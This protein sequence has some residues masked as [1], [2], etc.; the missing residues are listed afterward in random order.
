MVAA[1]RGVASLND[2]PLHGD[3]HGYIDTTGLML[4][5]LT[6]NPG[7]TIA[8]FNAAAMELTLSRLLLAAQIPSDQARRRRPRRLTGGV[9]GGTPH[10]YGRVDGLNDR[11]GAGRRS[12]PASKRSC[13]SGSTRGRWRR[14][15]S[16][17]RRAFDVQGVLQAFLQPGRPIERNHPLLRDA[18][19]VWDM[20]DPVTK[21]NRLI[22]EHADSHTCEAAGDAERDPSTHDSRATAPSGHLRSTSR[23]RSSVGRSNP[24]FP[25]LRLSGQGSDILPRQG[26]INGKTSAVIQ[27]ASENIKGH[28]VLFSQDRL[29]FQC[30]LLLERWDASRGD[31]R[32]P[33]SAGCPLPLG[34][35]LGRPSLYN[36]PRH[37]GH[38]TQGHCPR[39]PDSSPP[40]LKVSIVVDIHGPQ[41]N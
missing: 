40:H 31:S 4:Y 16:R 32:R 30:H 39:C 5:N 9:A 1:R 24:S 25:S 7:G 35:G 15:A 41:A 3:R 34:A 2:F 27:Y 22:A 26:N 33:R 17:R 28:Y 20:V 6:G 8:N 18:E 29:R 14:S 12:T 10:R 23:C 37:A 11:G 19:R 13:S 21:A 36:V 38:P